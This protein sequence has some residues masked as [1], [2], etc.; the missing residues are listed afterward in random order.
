LTCRCRVSPPRR[1]SWTST[2]PTSTASSPAWAA[3][4]T[5]QPSQDDTWQSCRC[6]LCCVVL[7]FGLFY[8]CRPLTRKS[9]LTGSVSKSISVCLFRNVQRPTCWLRCEVCWPAFAGRHLAGLQ[10]RAVLCG[11]WDVKAPVLFA[12]CG[13]NAG[14]PS[15]LAGWQGYTLPAPC[16]P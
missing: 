9:R 1:S 10:V 15:H 13:L 3:Q 4:G 16:M 11:A 6:G 8:S 5:T 12:F 2:T 14:Q 7:D